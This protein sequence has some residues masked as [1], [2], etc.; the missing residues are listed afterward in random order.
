[1]T[2]FGIK[3]TSKCASWAKLHKNGERFEILEKAVERFP[4]KQKPCEFTEWANTHFDLLLERQSPNRIVYKL[5][6]GLSTHD[7]IFHIY[8]GLAMLNFVARKQGIPI[9]HMAPQSLRPQLFGLSR[10]EKV[11]S[12]IS[13]YFG[14]QDTPWNKD[15][16]EAVSVALRKLIK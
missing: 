6:A 8:F 7:Q 13:D 2:V 4:S 3:F 14:E 10:L 16:R 5:P 1:M 12:Y 11:D 15:I 9:E